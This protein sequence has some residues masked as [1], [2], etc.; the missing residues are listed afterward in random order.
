MKGI[1]FKYLDTTLIKPKVFFSKANE[2]R[3]R[4]KYLLLLFLKKISLKNTAGEKVSVWTPDRQEVDGEGWSLWLI[5][6]GC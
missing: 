2:C 1:F 6:S 3:M 5:S 4:E